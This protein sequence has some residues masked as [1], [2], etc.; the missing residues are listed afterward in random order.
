VHVMISSGSILA[1]FV[2]RIYHIMYIPIYTPSRLFS[3]I[4]LRRF[5]YTV[6]LTRCIKF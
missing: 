4:F 3:D 1:I 2:L 5:N 6:E